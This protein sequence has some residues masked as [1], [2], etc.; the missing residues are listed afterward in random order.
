MDP[1]P[2]MEPPAPAARRRWPLALGVVVLAV[3]GAAIAWKWSF[4]PGQTK[5]RP[6]ADAS[7]APRLTFPTRYRNV[8]PDVAYVGDDQC[9]A[10][11]FR[12]TNSFHEHPM[13]RALGAP[14]AVRP[15]EAYD[16]SARNPFEAEG[17][18]YEVERRGE[19]VVHHETR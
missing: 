12:L 8:R 19:R 9:A 6:V 1:V 15:V 2:P 5:H 13:V 3:A 17:F 7:P 16:A 18:R 14:A 11:H 4:G 10:C